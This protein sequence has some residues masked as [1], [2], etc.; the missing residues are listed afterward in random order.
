MAE[1]ITAG[2]NDLDRLA[3]F[4]INRKTKH[5]FQCQQW[6]GIGTSLLLTW[7]ILASCARHILSPFPV[8]LSLVLVIWPQE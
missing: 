4:Y 5:L 3:A 2:N 7:R 1:F 6:S 8:P